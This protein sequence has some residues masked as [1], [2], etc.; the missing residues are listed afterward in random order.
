MAQQTTTVSSKN[1]GDELSSSEL[2]DINNTVNANAVDAETRLTALGGGG[3]LSV[4][5]IEDHKS[6]NTP[7]GTFTSGAWQTR[8][9]NTVT[10]DDSNIV[11]LTNNEFTLQSGVYLV[12]ASAPSYQVEHNKIRLYNITDSVT[13]AEGSNSFAGETSFSQGRSFLTTKITINDT[14]S[15]NIGHYGAKT[16]SNAGFG[17]YS[18][19]IPNNMIYTQVKITKI[20]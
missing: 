13:V 12:E 6:N 20:G 7:S 10:S 5:I 4:A 9:L 16:R 2:N 19:N 15:F 14:K 11:T 8:D 1:T 17:T 3:S 18:S